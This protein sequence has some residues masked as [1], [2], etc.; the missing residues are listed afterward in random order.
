[1]IY[2]SHWREFD[3]YKQAFEYIEEHKPKLVVEYGGGDSTYLIYK[4]VEEL[5]Y[6]GKVI[7]Y[8]DNI[9]YFKKFN[10]TY[11]ELKGI[12]KLVDIEQVDK[13]RGHVRYK[14]NIEELKDVEM[15]IID[16]P[17]Y[18]RYP[19]PTGSPSNLT[20]NLK[21]LNEHFNKNITYFIDGRS[22]CVDYYY[23]E[24][25]YPNYIKQIDK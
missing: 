6:G 7:G 25:K 16:G 8:E 10:E 5:N 2:R 12:L 3:K 11:P 1:M 24:L 15:V 18:K 22:G 17:D 21:E 14:H 13:K 20:T 23:K 19:T 4:C 9:E